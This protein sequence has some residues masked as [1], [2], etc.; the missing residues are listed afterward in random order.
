VE[1]VIGRDYGPVTCRGKK[2][3]LVQKLGS[4]SPE[5]LLILNS[6]KV[7]TVEDNGST[8]ISET[9]IFI[10]YSISDRELLCLVNKNI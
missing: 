1:D 9:R 2:T 3:A 10:I 8:E 5:V 7:D 6:S 4:F